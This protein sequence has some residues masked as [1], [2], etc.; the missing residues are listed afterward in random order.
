[1][2]WHCRRDHPIAYEGGNILRLHYR[3]RRDGKDNNFADWGY[4]TASRWDMVSIPCVT[5]SSS[6]NWRLILIKTGMY[7][8]LK[9]SGSQC[10]AP[11]CRKHL[12]HDIS[13]PF[14]LK[15]DMCPANLLP[16]V[17]RVHKLHPWSVFTTVIDYY[18]SIDHPAY[19]LWSWLVLKFTNDQG[20]FPK[21]EQLNC[22][23]C[24]N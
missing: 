15:I 23:P 19:D 21:A 16:F 9:C 10:R 17:A 4:R 11:I 2:G 24:D 1:M 13:P 18:I 12:P 7:R 3:P 6:Q 20:K 8:S 22:A 14:I 5:F